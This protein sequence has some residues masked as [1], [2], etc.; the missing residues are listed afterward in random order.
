MNLPLPILIVSAFTTLL[1][2]LSGAEIHVLP[3]DESIAS[4]EF[5]LL[6]GKKRENIEGLHPF[7]RSKTVTI[8]FDGDTEMRLEAANLPANDEGLRPSMLVN[9]PTGVKRPL[10]LLV[11]ND[12]SPIKVEPI[13]IE[14]DP[15]DFRYGTIKMVNA[16]G[17]NLVFSH[18]KK[19][20]RIPHGWNPT[21]VDPSG[22]ERNLIAKFFL[23]ESPNE[24]LYSSIWEYKPTMRQ[25]VLLFPSKDQRRG[26]VAFKFIV[27]DGDP[28]VQEEG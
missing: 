19:F 7:K 6:V 27:E 5:V 22:D 2:T 18:A 16:T 28:T 25:L 4:R 20:F 10:L 24:P 13:V 23:P 17:R 8:S 26:P 21:L 15:S 3:W 14:D 11:P 9:V 1:S 12:K